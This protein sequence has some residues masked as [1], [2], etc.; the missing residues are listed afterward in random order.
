[1]WVS[2]IAA[3]FVFGDSCG[4]LSLSQSTFLSIPACDG[5]VPSVSSYVICVPLT[6]HIQNIHRSI[7][8]PIRKYPLMHH[9][10]VLKGALQD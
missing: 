9:T 1:M 2:A 6:S 5:Q 8:L 10:A 4:T 3:L 7:M